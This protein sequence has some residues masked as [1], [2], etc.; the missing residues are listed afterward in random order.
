MGW[1]TAKDNHSHQFNARLQRLA[2]RVRARHLASTFLAL[3]ALCGI[4]RGSAEDQDSPA[5]EIKMDSTLINVPVI[6]TDMKDRYVPGLHAS[7]F[8]LYENGTSQEIKHF[9]SV[10]EPFNVA[11]LL[12]TSFSARAVID[13]IK[14][15]AKD[16]VRQLRPQDRAMI[17]T[18]DWQVRT[19]CSLTD[20]HKVLEN[21]IKKA[22]VA[23]QLGTMLRAAVDRVQQQ[24]FKPIKGRKA[25][26]LLTDGKD[27]GSQ[28]SA[29]S[30]LASASAGD[31]LIYSV[32]YTTGLPQ[33]RESNVGRRAGVRPNPDLEEQRDRREK[34]AKARNKD[35][36]DF[37]EK[38]SESSAGRY[39]Q[40]DLTNLRKTFE[41]IADELRNQYR[42]GFYP[43]DDR[44]GS[45][46]NI[47]VEVNRSDLKVSARSIYRLSE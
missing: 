37:L 4:L 24:T 20:D 14:Q 8:A 21:A 36:T 3:L 15:A 28:V 7:D 1:K 31:T 39:Y 5:F 29:R 6:V 26:V 25:I 13:D 45:T 19:L 40:S 2:F 30:L 32:F 41:K 9:D 22:A 47:K 16:F 10:E 33:E 35:A 38:L 27:A 43:V 42:L 23:D 46:H 34:E 17:V 11:L 44:M 18:F 12:D